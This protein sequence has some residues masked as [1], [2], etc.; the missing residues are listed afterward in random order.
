VV[1]RHGRRA[2]QG[3]LTKYS[4]GLTRE[5]YSRRAGFSTA[6]GTSEKN[7]VEGVVVAQADTRAVLQK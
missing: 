3:Q 1:L 4:P 6:A 2:G 5:I 7:V